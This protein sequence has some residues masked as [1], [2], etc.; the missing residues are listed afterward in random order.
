MAEH[1][2][3]SRV[4]GILEVVARA[5]RPVPL[6]VLAAQLDAPKSSLHGLVG[7]LLHRGYL[8][9]IDGGYRLGAGAHALLAP[10]GS[11]LPLL[12]GESCAEIA[13]RTG[14]TVTLATRV[15][16]RSVV[17]VHSEPSAF[18]VCYR[19][20][21]RERRPILPT[22]AGKLFL[23]HDDD[24]DSVLALADEDH[25]RRFLTEID[26]I[27]ASGMAFNRG[28]TVSDLGAVAVGVYE[29]DRLTAGITI[30]GPLTRVA[31]RLEYFGGLAQEVLT[32]D[33]FSRHGRQP[34]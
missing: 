4:V 21:L 31:E 28:E 29:D 6:S 26:S 12:L 23:A 15:G 8:S 19:P 27:R 3:V 7:G 5:R 24:R 18:E 22:S 14:E 25:R 13:V 33:G 2:T 30:A 1:R 17:Y 32:A 11:S 9:E 10:A 34:S 20:R 16:D